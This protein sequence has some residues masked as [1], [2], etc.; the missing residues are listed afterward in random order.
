ME[1][2]I[3]GIVII[4]LAL[5]WSA[6]AIE[7]FLS[8]YKFVSEVAAQPQEFM[9]RSVYILGVIEEGSLQ[10]EGSAY[11]FRLSDGN[12]TL[13]VIYDGQMPSDMKQSVG[14]TVIGVLVSKDTVKASSVLAK[15]PSKYE[16]T[17]KQSYAK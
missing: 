9:G 4:A 16:Q 8:P 2:L 12:A 3:L 11:R 7:N 15:C 17:L 13:N 6:S 5:L 10:R 14:I 1:K